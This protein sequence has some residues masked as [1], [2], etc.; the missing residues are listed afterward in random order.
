MSS[1]SASHSSTA[2]TT[3][4][5]RSRY[6]IYINFEAVLTI[7]N[8]LTRFRAEMLDEPEQYGNEDAARRLA[9]RPMQLESVERICFQVEE[10]QWFYEDFIRPLDPTL[11]SMSLR[12]F[13]LRIF[14][15]CPLL[16]EF[17]TYHHST[18]FSEFLAYKTRVPVRGAI[19]LN[20][21]MDEVVLVKGWKKGANWSFPRG[22][23]NKDEKDLDCAVR[24]VYE[25]TGFDLRRAGLVG[26]EPQ[27][28]YI[29]VTMREQHMRLYVFRGVPT[30]THFEPRTR[31]EISKIQWYKLSDLP[32]LKKTRQQQ[33][34][35]GEDLAINA[36]KFYMVAPFLVPL[37]KWI[38]LQIKHDMLRGATGDG[39]ASAEAEQQMAGEA[40]PDTESIPT[41]DEAL[42]ASSLQSSRPN[43]V[44]MLGNPREGPTIA[45]P[46]EDASA[47]LKRLLSVKDA[48]MSSRDTS[49][50][51]ANQRGV[52]LPN[53]SSLLDLLRNGNASSSTQH[54]SHS[55]PLQTPM[56]QV[57]ATPS[58]P[59]PPHHQPPRPPHM[60]RLP[61]PPSFP[62]PN[63]DPYELP[64]HPSQRL[65]SDHP[66]V[67]ANTARPDSDTSKFFSPSDVGFGRTLPPHQPL[68]AGP[69]TQGPALPPSKINPQPPRPYQ[70]TGDPN[71]VQTSQVANLHA[72]IIPP[73]SR[74]PPPK[75][76]SHS[77]ALLNV[78][79]NVKPL[80]ST[81]AL[82]LDNVNGSSKLQLQT[83][84]EP[85]ELRK[86]EGQDY[87]STS[88]FTE[89][90]KTWS[91]SHKAL[92]NQNIE[93]NGSFNG[94]P[95]SGSAHTK[96][97]NQHQDALLDLFR[98]P[99]AVTEKA[100]TAT[101]SSATLAPVEL[102]AQ[103]SP[104]IIRKDLVQ[105]PETSA[106]P[107]H[108]EALGFSQADMPKKILVTPHS[109]TPDRPAATVSGPLNMPHFVP[110]VTNQ[111]KTERLH[112]A[113]QIMNGTASK[114]ATPTS[115][116]ARSASAQA[117]QTVDVQP[118]RNSQA[119]PAPLQQPAPPS[120][121]FQP[122]ILRRPAQVVPQAQA[123]PASARVYQ[124]PVNSQ[125]NRPTD[126]KLSLFSI[127]STVDTPSPTSF[128]T[129]VSPLTEKLSGLDTTGAT[130]SR[131][132]IG[133]ITSLKGEEPGRKPPGSG[134]QTPHTPV[135]RSFLL[136][137]LEGVVK[138][139][140]L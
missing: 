107:E 129:V 67:H 72:P 75:L 139:E 45:Q 33:Q 100:T 40:P 44:D 51:G 17:S 79:K 57:I 91:P 90:P 26:D 28:K 38:N 15:H 30:D 89:S 25:E 2:S 11:P 113:K 120:K 81:D 14:Q 37:K 24:E 122:Q 52:H 92:R 7:V 88:R 21:A 68:S 56:E 29:E 82:D 42:A 80:N 127:P 60:S 114:R 27:M 48:S 110:A 19:M 32:T 135:D 115:I 54:P 69:L 5:D 70:R 99:S 93:T 128:S 108:R 112:A 59:E 20:E 49:Y 16:S 1:S 61:P 50:M 87:R 84:D 31:K 131:S 103:P 22:K 6:L 65:A 83:G 34:G 101:T 77:L 39:L 36:N 134:S 64:I 3:V 85:G 46:S 9:G 138:G 124:P 10:A 132:R 133:S 41:P 125:V 116:L 13:C 118:S 55:M 137:Y 58:M 104:A 74:L 119:I 23:I 76:T 94:V 96:P 130:Y 123:G 102:S 98:K 53:T 97:R 109:S 18:A 43:D 126:H 121:P 35:R 66:I 105:N 140:L 63:L 78:F 62:F 86:R 106:K 117:P 47:Q 136:G 111:G 4:F 95:S 8:K 73:A 71:F 12:S